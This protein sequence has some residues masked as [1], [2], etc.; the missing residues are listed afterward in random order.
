MGKYRGAPHNNCNL[1]YRIP[2]FIPVFLHNNSHYDTH[3]FIKELRK[4][5][6]KIIAIPNTDQN[7]IS[8]TKQIYTREM[9]VNTNIRFLDSFKFMRSPLSSLVSNISSFPVLSSQFRT[10]AD[11][12]KDIS[13]LTKKGIYPHD[14]MDSF[15]RFK[16]TR[17]PP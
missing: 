6:G 4:S 2:T 1:N 15:E 9:G 5:P 7:Y 16:E 13:L 10:E 11:F 12:G 14:D 8:F 3:L 17:L